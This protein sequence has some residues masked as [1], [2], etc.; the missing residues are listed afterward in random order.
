LAAFARQQAAL[1]R[2]GWRILYAEDEEH[3]EIVVPFDAAPAPIELS[4]RIDR[5]DFHEATA[6]VRIIDYKTGD[7]SK[8][9]DQVHRQGE[10]WTDLQLPLY[11]RLWHGLHLDVPTQHRIELGFF[12]LPKRLEE[13]GFRAASWDD[14][15]LRDA[16]A[17]ARDVV[18]R[19]A[20]ESPFWPP[21]YDP[22]PKYMEEFAAICL[23]N[24][25]GRPPLTDEETNG[26]SV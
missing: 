26:E 4:G 19:L 14:A 22:V 13:A 11:E 1:V 9:P 25:Q 7:T 15:A 5:I 8:S 16:Q 23:D 2:D 3:D 18:R 20:S 6:A 21:V 12:N 24:V 10:R 17:V